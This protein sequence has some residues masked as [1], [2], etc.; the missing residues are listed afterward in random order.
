[1]AESFLYLDGAQ[2]TTFETLCASCRFIW[3]LVVREWEG[4]VGVPD[5]WAGRIKSLVLTATWGSVAFWEAL[6]IPGG[7]MWG[8]LWGLCTASPGQVRNHGPEEHT[9][10]PCFPRVNPVT[11]VCRGK[12]RVYHCTHFVVGQVNVGL[13]GWSR[14]AVCVWYTDR[15]KCAPWL[16]KALGCT[17]ASDH[18]MTP[19]IRNSG[20]FQHSQGRK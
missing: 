20:R 17:G 13:T 19:G 10:V 14:N 5:G 9:A 2:L 4:Q 15:V 3:S 1:M 16:R 18:A 6:L 11:G 7:G 8:T 12:V